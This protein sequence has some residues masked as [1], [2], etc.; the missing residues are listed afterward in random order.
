MNITLLFFGA[1]KELLGRDESRLNVPE[2]TMAGALPAL[3][4]EGSPHAAFWRDKILYA[5]NR[6]HAHADTVLKEGDEVALMP[7]LAG[8]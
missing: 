4:L 2:R 7:P 3:V 6:E 8:G 1:L 5:V